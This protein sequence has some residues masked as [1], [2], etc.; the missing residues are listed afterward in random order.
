MVAKWLV[1]RRLPWVRATEARDCGAAVFASI[2]GYYRHH[3]SLEQARQLVHADR[4]GTTLAGLRDGG[5]AIG[6]DARPAQ[7]I[8]DALA[9]I[10]LPAIVHT[11]GREGHYLA[12][13]R[14]TPHAVTLL[15]PN[16]GLRRMVRAEFEA[17]W[18][19]YLVEYR[20]TPALHPRAPDVRPLGLFLRF[21]RE[22]AGSLLLALLFALVATALGWT[23]SFFL[24]TLIDRILPNREIGLLAALGT[25]LVLVSG[26]QAL[27]QFGRQWLAARI[28]RQI[29][30]TYSL[31]FIDHLLRLPM[32]VF[33][34]RCVAGLVL[35]INQ[36][37]G[38][39]Q[40]VSD[41]L[42]TLVAD[43][44]MF[45][46]ALG[47]LALFDPLAALIALAAVPLMLVV[48]L[49]LNER[50][51]ATQFTMI[52][53]MEAFAGQMLDT[54]EGLRAIKTFSAEARFRSFLD[55]QLGAM[56]AARY[57]NRN[58][59]IL[60]NAWSALATALVSALTLWYGAAR[61]LAGQLTPGDLIVLFGMVVFYLGPIQRLPTMV[62]TIRNALI[63]ITRLEEILALPDEQARTRQSALPLPT[64]V[65]GQIAFK[66][67]SFGYKPRQRVLRDVSLV[68]APGE[69]VAI[70]GE[71]GSGKTSLANL[72]AGFYLPITGD[73][74]I[75]G[76]STRDIAPDELRQAISA[77]FQ[78]AHLF[79]HSLHANITMLGEVDA[80]VVERATR[81]ANASGFIN[82]LLRGYATQVAR[83]GDNFS[84]G[85]AQRIALARA[86]LKDAPI[87]ILDEA[88]SN[89]DGATEQGILQA[90]AENRRGRTTV[91]IAHRL[92]TVVQADRIIV[93]DDGAIVEAGTHAE[94]LARRGRYYTLFHGQVIGADGAEQVEESLV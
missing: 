21:A 46:A 23:F 14:W 44:V 5:R 82:D 26:I 63:S 83:G 71:T 27:L 30:H 68:I 22:H 56:I 29:Q 76:I 84:S 35:R 80:A 41:L 2:A 87:L 65:Q 9:H 92:S 79:Q 11:N 45:L 49:L 10:Q 88:T 28:G 15:D 67:V 43:G 48:I 42:V 8:Y 6:L 36:V 38:V 1:Y 69:M 93:L 86:L 89:L 34:A 75:D 59:L 54:F 66:N 94:L 31:R 13:Y 64:P 12:L 70:V 72:I 18:S 47:V 58:A 20:P 77:V 16:R 37:D 3:L 32:P 51:Y 53:R 81:Q 91:L 24:R 33:D 62:L 52:A 57:A 90:L 85:Q 73:V 55:E 17:E 40:A 39:Q 50:V 60:P 7:A 78:D 74:C 4:D 61:V 25:G 19:G